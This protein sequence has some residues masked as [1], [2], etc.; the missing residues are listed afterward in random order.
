ML[1]IGTSIIGIGKV[2]GSFTSEKIPQSNLSQQEVK[3]DSADEQATGDTIDGGSVAQNESSNAIGS[4]TNTGNLQSNNSVLAAAATPQATTA[5]STGGGGSCVI[6]L[7]GK[8]YN[9]TSLLTT[10]SG[11][12]VFACGTDMSA[13]YQSRH[14]TNVSRMQPYL[15]STTGGLTSINQSA[16]PTFTPAPTSNPGNTSSG[17]S[18]TPTSSPS[19]S[20]GSNSCI[21]TLFGKQYNITSLLTTHSGGN[22][23]NC[24]TDMSSIYQ[25]RHGTNVSRMQQY[26]IV[27]S[28]PAP[29]SGGSTPA[30]T[31]NPTPT[32]TPT[33]STPTPTP[34]PSGTCIIT[35]FGKQY[36]VTNLRNTHSGPRGSFFACGTDMSAIYQSQ[37]GTNMTRMQPY[38]VTN[39][40][41]TSPSPAPTPLPS[42]IPP[43]ITPTPTP[44]RD[45]D[46]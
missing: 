18:P 31:N 29:T 20:G 35:L 27:N 46:D 15:V 44:Y 3:S 9:I 25:S 21:V 34:I 19:N 6:T 16:N 45:D 28:T 12:N 30:P 23:F 39:S 24:G 17:S 32:P 40:G 22:V 4:K 43:S 8:Q 14:G 10:H 7:F 11:G 2:A 33:S 13:S 41:G 5:N 1:T 26:L 36:N 37:H 38:L 42:G